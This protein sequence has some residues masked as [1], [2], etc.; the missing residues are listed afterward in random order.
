MV[1][2]LLAFWW[3][4]T[5]KDFMKFTVKEIIYGHTRKLTFK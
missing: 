5:V 2:K 3:C 4:V 1:F